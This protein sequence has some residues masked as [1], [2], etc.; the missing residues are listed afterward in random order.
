ASRTVSQSDKRQESETE[1]IH[2]PNYT[3]TATTLRFAW[4]RRHYHLRVHRDGNRARDRS[5]T[6]PRARNGVGVTAGS[7]FC[8]CPCCATYVEGAARP[9]VPRAAACPG[10]RVRVRCCV[11]ERHGL[12]SGY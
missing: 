9:I 6:G 5:E 11:G 4:T 2:N 7:R 8:N 12:S 1:T 10:T 3:A